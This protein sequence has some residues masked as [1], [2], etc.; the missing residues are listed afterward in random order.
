MRCIIGINPEER[1]HQQDV[2]INVTMECDVPDACITDHI[3]N[4]VNYKTVNK[5]IIK[6]VG[7][8]NFNLI[9]TLAEKIAAIC[10]AHEKVFGVQ[11]MVD[12]PGALRFAD[13]VA[14]EITRS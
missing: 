13:S 1:C 8:S 9:E 4:T 2:V 3:A 7:E 5:E 11:V 6:M 12:K 14:V 10:L